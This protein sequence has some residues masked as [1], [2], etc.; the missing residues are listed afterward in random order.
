LSN[1]AGEIVAET[2]IIEPAA[3]KLDP[4][5]HI[6]IPGSTNGSSSKLVAILSYPS[7][8]EVDHRELL[9]ENPPSTG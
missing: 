4:T 5:L 3:W 2:S 8:G 7:I 6:R 9:I 1:P